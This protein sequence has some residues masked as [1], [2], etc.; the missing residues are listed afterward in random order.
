ME[1]LGKTNPVHFHFPVFIAYLQ[2]CQALSDQVDLVQ[3][4]QFHLLLSPCASVL[5]GEATIAPAV[6]NG[7]TPRDAAVRNQ[8]SM[9]CRENRLDHFVV[10]KCNCTYL[11][12][13]CDTPI[14]PG[15]FPIFLSHSSTA[16]LF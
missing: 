12:A 3:R 16:Y 4:L 9:E 10:Q 1:E 8:L 14:R 2:T 6:T 7:G 5:A 13:S 15:S 11:T